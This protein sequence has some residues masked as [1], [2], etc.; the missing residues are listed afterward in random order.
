MWD[1]INRKASSA[2]NAPSRAGMQGLKSH[3]KTGE[4]M[5][6]TPLEHRMAKIMQELV[7]DLN[8]SYVIY[9]FCSIYTLWKLLNDDIYLY[10]DDI[11][12]ACTTLDNIFIN[13][14]WANSYYISAFGSN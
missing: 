1:W 3:T 9:E 10:Y 5:K 8:F 14:D 6:N 4:D 12:C 11:G 13:M 7:N 2:H